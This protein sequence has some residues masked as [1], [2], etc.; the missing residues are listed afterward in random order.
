MA[1]KRASGFIIMPHTKEFNKLQKNIREEY[2]GKPVPKRFQ[3]RYGKRYD[4]EDVEEVSFA[5][6]NKLGIKK[7]KRH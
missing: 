1:R 2:L 5:V 3:N 6:A 7:D 4:E